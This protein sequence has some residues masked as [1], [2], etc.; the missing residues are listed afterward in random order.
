MAT[1]VS[2]IMTYTGVSS[3]TANYTLT[4]SDANTIIP[5]SSSSAT[6]ITVPTDA[7]V[8]FDVGTQVMIVQSGTGQVTVAAATPATTSVNGANGLRTAAQYSIISLIKTS[9]NNWVVG[10]DTT[11]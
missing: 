7:S 9:A 10:G 1:K 2:Q 4:I 11:A 5:L 8:A 6:T 3:K